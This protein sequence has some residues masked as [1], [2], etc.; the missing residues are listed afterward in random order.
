M[1]KRLLSLLLVLLMVVGMLPMS[2][3][4]TENDVAYVTIAV[5]GDLK[6]VRYPVNLTDVNNSGGYDLDDALSL[7]HNEE[8]GMEGGYASYNDPTYGLGVSKL[9]GDTST[10]FGYTVNGNMATGLAN[11]VKAGDEI[12][13]WVYTDQV[14]PNG[15]PDI[16]AEFDKTTANAAAGEAVEVTLDSTSVANGAD[17]VVYKLKDNHKLGAEAETDSV[18]DAEGK[19]SVAINEA[20]TFVITAAP[21]SDSAKALVPPYCT[22]TVGESLVSSDV[23]YTLGS[24]TGA[25]GETVQ[26]PL[27]VEHG[28]TEG[29][30]WWR[31]TV[32]LD[33]GLELVSVSNGSAASSHDIYRSGTRLEFQC[34]G[35]T[36]NPMPKGEL[37]VLNVKI[38]E[39]A[40][41]G[42]YNVGLSHFNY[43]GAFADEITDLVTV[44]NEGTVTV[45]AA[46]AAPALEDVQ[47]VVPDGLTTEDGINYYG[48]EVMKGYTFGY[49]TVPADVEV[50]AQSWTFKDGSNNSGSGSGASFKASVWGAGKGTLT[51]SV[52]AGD[53]TVN[54]TYYIHTGAAPEPEEPA[55]PFTVTVGETAM[56]LVSKGKQSFGEGTSEC[57]TYEVTVPAGTTQ[58]TVASENK[59]YFYT[60]DGSGL[61]LGTSKIFDVTG[62]VV[63]KIN[64]SSVGYYYLSVKF[65]QATEPEETAPFG[66]KADG[67]ELE[68]PSV[69]DS[70]E[71]CT[72]N[73]GAA[74]EMT[75]TLPAGTKEI[76][77]TGDSTIEVMGDHSWSYYYFDFGEVTFDYNSEVGYYCVVING[78]YTVS[79]HI[80]FESEGSDEPDE[81]EEPE[82]PEMPFTVTVGGEEMTDF[83]LGEVSDPYEGTKPLYTVTIPEGTTDATITWAE[84]TYTLSAYDSSLSYFAAYNGHSSS[85]D[86]QTDMNGDGTYDFLQ[87]YD[88]GWGVPYWI[89]FTSGTEEPEEEPVDAP[90]TVTVN[91]EEMT[92][93]TLGEV[94]DPYEGT[95]PLYTVTIPE[96]TTDATITW[97]EGTYTL[98]A[99]DSALSYFYA[100]MGHS[101]SKDVQT[102]MNGDGAYDFLQVYDSGWGVPYWITF[103]SGNEDPDEPASANVVVVGNAEAWPGDLIELSI[104]AECVENDTN[105]FGRRFIPTLALPDGWTIV[106]AV[107]GEDLAETVWELYETDLY[108]WC[109]N[110]TAENYYGAYLP[111]GE[112]MKFQIQVAADAEAGEYTVELASAKMM[113]D[114]WGAGFTDFELVG[115]TVIIS[116]PEGKTKLD[117]PVLTADS[118]F[119]PE[120]YIEITVP[121]SEVEPAAIVEYAISTDGTTWSEWQTGNKFTEVEDGTKY[122][123]RARYNPFNDTYYEASDASNVLEV[124][125][126]A[127]VEEPVIFT[128]GDVI[129]GHGDTVYIPVSLSHSFDGLKFSSFRFC[130]EDN[131]NLTLV[132]ATNGSDISGSWHVDYAYPDHRAVFVSVSGGLAE[133]PAGETVIL[134]YKI[135][136]DATPGTYKLGLDQEI[137]DVFFRYSVDGSGAYGT[138]IDYPV[139]I[140]VVEG[141]VTIQEPLTAPVLTDYTATDD[142]ITVIAPAAVENAHIEYAIS[143]NGKTYGEWQESNVFENL[144]EETTYYIIARYIAEEGNE[145]VDSYAGEPLEVKTVNPAATY[146]VA[147]VTAKSGE[148]VDVAVTLTHE[149]VKQ[150]TSFQIIPTAAEGLTLQGAEAGADLP[151]GWKIMLNDGVVTVYRTDAAAVP[152]GEVVVLTYVVSEDAVDGEY[153]VTLSESFTEDGNAFIA[154]DD[155]VL[156]VDGTVTAG[157]VT[158]KNMVLGDLDG[159]SV[160]DM[161]DL[162]SLRRYLAGWDDYNAETLNLSAIDLNEDGVV[163][164]LDAIILSRHLAD[165]P[166]YKTLPY[167]K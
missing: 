157:G 15:N 41:A 35:G 94:S 134:E 107:A 123:V 84:G 55:A 46:S 57:D 121:A 67:V 75:V 164:M 69:V 127:F 8:T 100:Y 93:I 104:F 64:V 48:A 11:A 114:D 37:A 54:K 126:K 44:V 32:N 92:K 129:G 124:T 143:A 139:T 128:V 141:T 133:I 36:C 76:T 13:A 150:A 25:P 82:V 151:E 117:A 111:S 19:A 6:L 29:L 77:I 138:Y 166:D 87:V 131:E 99:Y 120:T 140:Q 63:Y 20:G 159:D 71:G 160:V 95:K 137:E 68:L 21:K 109:L 132:E 102:D 23:I 80:Y 101:S 153:A 3:F 45:E 18:F 59:M 52:V 27:S 74:K 91:G 152:S 60:P 96:G 30:V 16:L 163:N 89:T 61:G 39:D 119:A 85:K 22:V 50:D 70:A 118:V 146:T 4:A 24:V 148:T 47:L 106:G 135:H 38:A 12:Y 154:E 65:E 66:V 97:A 34:G 125:T 78:D 161:K 162:V 108:G 142:T 110:G 51:L 10:W 53:E 43:Y 122:Y 62:D 14:W 155:S 49:T 58:I 113:K 72:E 7:A 86:V 116:V 90:F 81:P 56:E 156:R 144:A 42:T 73:S 147:S 9:W 130:L 83:T 2:V 98:S 17:V 105:V 5:E 149:I 145:C 165:W 31:F 115:G 79:Y 158:V 26:V 28:L 167:V 103:T 33:D 1:K 112:L 88:S 40:A 136:E